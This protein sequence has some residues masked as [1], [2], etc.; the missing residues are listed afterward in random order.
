MGKPFCSLQRDGQV[1]IITMNRPEK[2]NAIT[3]PDS[4]EMSAI[5]DDYACD[6]TLR[7]AILT[8]AGDTAY[9]AGHDL[10]DA[11]DAPM[12]PSG[13]AGITERHDLDKPVIAAINGYALGGGLGLALACDLIIAA[14]NAEL[15]IVQ[16]RIGG[17]DL[18]G[19]V[20]RL[21]RRIPYH[22]GMSM[23]LTGRRFSAAEVYRWGLINELV[24]AGRAL[25]A[26]RRWA[27]DII[28]CAPLTVRVHRRLM[29]E[30][31]E[32]EAFIEQIARDQKQWVEVE[33][34][35][36]DLHEGIKAF[37]EKRKPVWKGS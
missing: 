5:F 23:V 4:F 6:P 35:T 8:G 20:H 22:L 25:E 21:A 16:G 24:P 18:S 32:G 2:M 37:A 31:A 15:G 19:G 33:F 13:F 29:R 27:D 3:A 1:L 12:P 14:E 34:A 28:A 36:E 7:V 9:S 10:L 17:L 30:S 11:P 26:A